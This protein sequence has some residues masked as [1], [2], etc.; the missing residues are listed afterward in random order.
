MYAQ[1]FYFL[2]PLADV[3]DLFVHFTSFSSCVVKVMSLTTVLIVCAVDPGV[4]SVMSS[5]ILSTRQEGVSE[6]S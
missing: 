2:D 4:T 3:Y 1:Q 5:G 6:F